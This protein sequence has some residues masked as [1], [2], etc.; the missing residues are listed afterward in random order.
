[1]EKQNNLFQ[2]PMR[3][4]VELGFSHQHPN[5]AIKLDEDWGIELER[6]VMKRAVINSLLVPLRASADQLL[7]PRDE[8]IDEKKLES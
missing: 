8:A 2:C 5:P 3:A 7:R 4:S 6:D 1:M